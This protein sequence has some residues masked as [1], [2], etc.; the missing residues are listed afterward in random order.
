[1]KVITAKYRFNT[2]GNCEIINITDRVYLYLNKVEKAGLSNG[3]LTLFVPGSTGS[4]TT[5]EFEEGLKL[6]F[7]RIMERIAPENHKYFH[8]DKWGDGDGHSHIR[9]SIIGPALVLPFFSSCRELNGKGECLPEKEDGRKPRRLRLGDAQHIV[10]VDFD[11]KPR[12]R[13]V[14]L[15]AMGE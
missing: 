13:T 4:L 3:L 15:Q 9:A 11:I 10:F 12:Y 7:P 1:M 6:D 5:I 2:R 14:Y 8:D